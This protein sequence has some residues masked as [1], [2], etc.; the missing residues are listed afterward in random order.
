MLT[1]RL[2]SPLPSEASMSETTK[3]SEPAELEIRIDD[4]QSQE[5]TT[6]ESERLVGGMRAGGSTTVHDTNINGVPAACDS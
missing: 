4:L 6:D 3:K 1:A 5:L 2:L